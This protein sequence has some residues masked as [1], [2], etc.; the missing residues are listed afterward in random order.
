MDEKPYPFLGENREPVPMCQGDTQ[1]IDSEY[2]R[3]G[4]CSIFVFTKVLAGIMLVLK[5]IEPQ[6]TGQRKFATD[7]KNAILTKKKSF[8]R[9][10]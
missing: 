8:I 6:L 1:K 5:N 4:T 7:W 3:K 10:D 2:T 9:G